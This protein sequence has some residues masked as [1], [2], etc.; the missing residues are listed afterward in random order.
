[1]KPTVI[2]QTIV[3]Q[4]SLLRIFNTNATVTFIGTLKLCHFHPLVCV[5]PL[6][7]LLLLDLEAQQLGQLSSLP[8]PVEQPQGLPH[9]RSR[10]VR[11]EEHEGSWGEQEEQ[12]RGRRKGR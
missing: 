7:L 1:M 2:H 5:L 6:P 8:L 12:R 9:G 3:F 11:E 4:R 10:A